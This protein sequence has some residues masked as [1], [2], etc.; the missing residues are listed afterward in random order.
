MSRR[1]D[2]NAIAPG[3]RAFS[4]EK[5]GYSRPHV[6]RVEPVTAAGA[7]ADLPPTPTLRAILFDRDGTLVRDVPHNGDP[8]QVELVP[9]AAKALRRVRR[10]GLLTGVVTNQSGIGLGLLT[11]EQVDAVCARLDELAGPL[12]PVLICPHVPDEGCACRKPAPGLVLSAAAALGVRPEECA[13]IGDIGADV[14]AARAAGARPVLVPT[15][16]TLPEEVAAAP[17]VADDLAGAL[18]LLLPSVPAVA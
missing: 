18:D 6:C 7:A 3:G 8:V 1:G 4:E 9:G 5:Y 11:R 12:G 13:V 17:E 2:S 15:P 10:A 14:G 16:V